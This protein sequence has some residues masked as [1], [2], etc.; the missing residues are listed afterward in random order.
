MAVPIR[1]EGR[2]VPLRGHPASRDTGLALRQ[3]QLPVI[4]SGTVEAYFSGA[5]S[6]A[7]CGPGEHRPTGQEPQ[8]ERRSGWV[9]Q[10]FRT[11]PLSM[12]AWLAVETGG[13]FAAWE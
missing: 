5:S 2:H 3:G 6:Q 11:R 12:Q 4:K 1:A 9:L 13:R 7:K 8:E 10:R